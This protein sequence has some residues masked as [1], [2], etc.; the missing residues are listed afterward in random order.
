MMNFGFKKKLNMVGKASQENREIFK[1]LSTWNKELHLI[2]L[3]HKDRMMNLKL[4]I[5]RTIT[6]LDQK[7]EVIKTSDIIPIPLLLIWV[8]GPY[9]SIPRHNM[10]NEDC[11]LQRQPS[12]YMK[13]WVVSE[14]QILKFVGLISSAFSQTHFTSK[15]SINIQV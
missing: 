5:W 3:K 7:T 15:E 1:S 6:W 2:Y 12:P 4:S 13:S 10:I 8:H 14:K 9:F 11:L